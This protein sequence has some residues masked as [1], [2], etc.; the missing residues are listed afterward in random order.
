MPVVVALAAVVAVAVVRAAA[1]A[2]AAAAVYCNSQKVY[3]GH[4]VSLLRVNGSISAAA[5][6]YSEQSQR[7]SW[8][9]LPVAFLQQNLGSIQW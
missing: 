9:G 4:S 1:A 3:D 6:Q 2:A 5:R 7:A 8:L